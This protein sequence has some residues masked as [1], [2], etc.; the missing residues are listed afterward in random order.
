[1]APSFES[2]NEIVPFREP[3]DYRRV[4]PIYQLYKLNNLQNV[5]MR[6]YFI[7]IHGW[8]ENYGAFARQ[9]HSDYGRIAGT[10]PGAGARFCTPAGGGNFN[11]G[12][13]RRK[14]GGD[15]PA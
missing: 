15:R 1:M 14:I 13:Q 7:S 4:A 3:L 5:K 12:A 9:V 8:E 11:R 2:G 6:L 10:G